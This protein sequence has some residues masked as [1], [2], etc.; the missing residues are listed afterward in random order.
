[1]RIVGERL[2]LGGLFFLYLLFMSSGYAA[3]P[4]DS[5]VSSY[6]QKGFQKCQDAEAMMEISY[7]RTRQKIN[8]FELYL[9][10]IKEALDGELKSLELEDQ[11]RLNQC[12]GLKPQLEVKEAQTI[13]DKAL[14]ECEKAFKLMDEK[15]F[16]HA[17]NR[18]SVYQLY[19]FEAI[20]KAPQI[21]LRNRRALRKCEQFSQMLEQRNEPKEN[22]KQ[23]G[24]ISMQET[25][26]L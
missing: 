8:Q 11:Q 23:A 25:A 21:I 19:R 3:L 2:R 13:M 15:Q 5:L 20:S 9:N 14:G 24:A 16:H 6:L 18:N 26:G 1:M 12:L 7:K 17:T 10:E 4:E 22:R